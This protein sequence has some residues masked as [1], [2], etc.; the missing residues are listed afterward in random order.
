MAV[1]VQQAASIM[2]ASDYFLFWLDTKLAEVL[3]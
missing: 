3:G 1:D 2:N